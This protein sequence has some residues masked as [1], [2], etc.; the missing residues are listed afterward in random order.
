MIQTDP[1]VLHCENL[2]DMNNCIG[3]IWGE[4]HLF[5]Y[6]L[7]LWSLGMV[8]VWFGFWCVHLGHSCAA[9]QLLV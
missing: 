6:L 3:C 4:N 8:K 7:F 5:L 2:F 1:E 9:T